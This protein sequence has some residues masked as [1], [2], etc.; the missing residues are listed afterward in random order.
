MTAVLSPG[1]PRYG[2]MMAAAVLGEATIVGER[3]A[4][5]GKRL[6]AF[7]G[8]RG[9]RPN[10][11]STIRIGREFF[12][13]AIRDYDD[14]KEK[15]WREAIQNAVDAGAK[16]VKC[17]T[18]EEEIDG[19]KGVVVVC[20]DDGR[21]MDEDTV[22]NKFLVL[23]GT[24]KTEAG[25][26][27]GFGKAKELLLLPWIRW[28]IET[29]DVVVDG[30]GIDYDVT[31]ATVARTGTKLTVIMPS[32]QCTHDSA[33]ISY[34]EKSFIPHVKFS[35][36]GNPIKAALKPGEAVRDFGDA[37]RL[38]YDKRHKF[39]SNA[40]LVRANG[41]FMFGMWVDGIE[42][43]LIVEL[44][45]P[46]IEL[47]TA[48]RDGF[49]DRDLRRQ[50]ESFVSELA[51]DVR[52]A[53]KK[54][55]G[56]IRDKYVS[57]KKF[58]ASQ[59][60]IEATMM[61]HAGDFSARDKVG[62]KLENTSIEDIVEALYSG[63]EVEGTTTVHMTASADTEVPRSPLRLSADP[64]AAMAMLQATSMRGSQHVENAIRQLAWEPD[65]FL[66]NEIEGWKVPQK[67]RPES[68]PVRVRQLLQFW[69]ELCRFVMVQL[70][71][72][73]EYGVGFLFS[74]DAR[75]QYIHEENEHWLMVNP[76]KTDDPRDAD[77]FKLTKKED[78]D[79]MYAIAVHECTHIADGISYHDE[80]FASALTR[81]MA[82]T[83]NRSRQIEAI[84]KSVTKR[85]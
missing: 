81:N 25:T 82:R 39:Y 69:A 3:Y 48:N 36:N 74:S 10:A 21:G 4:D 78:I 24:T 44:L 38:H 13:G 50:V 5:D 60:E 63:R 12:S 6:V 27:G 32:D 41:L 77:T 67:F 15:W 18:R 64:D 14:W 30:A 46:S 80:S 62:A 53:L 85:A 58:K 16:S 72:G 68:M 84:R 7:E 65:Y 56:L 20:E 52:S 34:I 29:R 31:R 83:A 22:I 49:R 2:A 54:K 8:G 79:W 70:G 23:G 42:G 71:S 28:R 40:M 73:V 59:R 1:D 26:T 55:K 61:R 11:Q 9:L 51:K 37:A 47:L 76:M 17:S 33:A 19:V 66:V 45:R 35:V 57:G 75:G 43:K